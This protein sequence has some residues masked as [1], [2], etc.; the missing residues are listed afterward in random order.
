RANCAHCSGTATSL[1]PAR[2][3]GSGSKGAIRSGR[4]R[5]AE[6]RPYRVADEAARWQLQ[7]FKLVVLAVFGTSSLLLNWFIT[8]RVA[9]LLGYPVEF[10][11]RHIFGLYDPW[12]WLVW[13]LRWR[14]AD[15]L[16]R[17]WASCLH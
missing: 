3:S 14:E 6:Y 8:E 7:R 15:E 16:Q 5:M 11:P 17:L 4:F 12:E 2:A 1:K 13:W 9:A 10:G